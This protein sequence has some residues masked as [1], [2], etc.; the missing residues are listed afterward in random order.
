MTYMDS[1]KNKKTSTKK[2]AIISHAPPSTCLYKGFAESLQGIPAFKARAT[3]LLAWP[4]NKSIF[5]PKFYCFG[6]TVI[7]ALGL[8]FGNTDIHNKP[9]WTNT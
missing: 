7:Q 2:F 3:C 4:Y 9:L 6:L 8:E 1:C 5:A